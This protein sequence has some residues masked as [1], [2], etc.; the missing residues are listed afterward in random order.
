MVVAGSNSKKS[1]NKKLA[2][3]AGK[4]MKDVELKVFDLNDFEMPIYSGER[5]EAS[6]IPQE[7][8]KLLAE[9][10]A[11]DGVIISLAEHNGSYSAAFKNIFDWCSR[12]KQKVWSDKPMLLMATSPG[13]RGGAGVLQNAG[14][15]FPHLG[16]NVVATFS[17]PKFHDNFSDNGIK[18]GDLKSK[19]DEA[20]T[21][22]KA[23][24]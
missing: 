21:A 14:N 15:S 12:K 23:A 19:L 11:T 8:E 5:E 16:A 20:L 1:I 6:G 9:I 7:A 18:D 24:V 3:F 17:L 4:Q 10:E 2:H 22:F 13:G